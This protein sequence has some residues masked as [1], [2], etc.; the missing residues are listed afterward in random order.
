M[1]AFF[2]QLKRKDLR[3]YK[4][5][6]DILRCVLRFNFF[7]FMLFLQTI[8]L[9][10]CVKIKNLAK[11]ELLHETLNKKFFKPEHWISKTLKM[12]KLG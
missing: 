7:S 4:H 8:K 2:Q 10:P 9:K 5:S 1:V 12:L 3:F 6:K 11:N